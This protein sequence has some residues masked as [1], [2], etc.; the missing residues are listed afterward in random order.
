MTPV[1]RAARIA[2]WT[3]AGFAVLFLL[4]PLVVT[5]MVS[6]S[7]SPVFTLPAPEWSLRWYQRIPKLDSFW[8]ALG[9][10]V[11]V[12]AFSTDRKS[13]RLNSS[14]EWISRMPSSA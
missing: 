3:M 1:E 11:Q 5:L 13:T 6:F 7:S 10:S 8:S 14:H 9:L 12:A 4:A 2:V